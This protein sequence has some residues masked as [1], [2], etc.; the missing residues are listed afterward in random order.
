MERS[1]LQK[2]SA[3]HGG[4]MYFR[5]TPLR[6]FL[7]CSY[8]FFRLKAVSVPMLL[9]PE[10]AWRKHPCYTLIE[11]TGRDWPAKAQAVSD[12]P[13]CWLASACE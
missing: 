7:S 12:A 9:A 2:D 6:Y 10:Y 13:T 4:E 1:L 3:G 5:V 11:N 8:D